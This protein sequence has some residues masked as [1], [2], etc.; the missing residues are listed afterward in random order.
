MI[1]LIFF[2]F[3]PCPLTLNA[4]KPITKD[5][6][7]EGWHNG[8]LWRSY[9]KLQ[10]STHLLGMIEEIILSADFLQDEYLLS[11]LTQGGVTYDELET[12]MD[13]FYA[14]ASNLRIPIAY[15]YVYAV[16]KKRG[17]APKELEAFAAS[18]RKRFNK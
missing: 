4:Q 12:E 16:G 5:E 17:T 7:T 6:K 13:R 8:N 14:K 1:L 3:L 10:R 18:L 15:A 9:P 2:V 11:A